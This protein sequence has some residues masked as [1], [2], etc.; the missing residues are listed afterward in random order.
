MTVPF[1]LTDGTLVPVAAEYD[2]VHF[3]AFVLHNVEAAAPWIVTW[4]D[5]IN[6]W[7][8]RWDDV[9]V[10]FARF[11]ALLRASEQEVWLV[12]NAET[13]ETQVAFAAEAER[14][15]S[16]VVHTSSCTLG[17]RGDDPTNH[18]V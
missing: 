10:T 7:D 4:T 3:H 13:H 11:A 12:H 9:V 2:G 16:R 17:C 8:E 5:G 15:L 6:W 18:Q 1:E 14:F